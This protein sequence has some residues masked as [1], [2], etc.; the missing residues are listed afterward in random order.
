MFVFSAGWSLS[1]ERDTRL[2]WDSRPVHQVQLVR[3]LA[4]PEEETLWVAVR[5][6]VLRYH[7]SS[8]NEARLSLVKRLRGLLSQ[9]S[10]AIKNQLVA[11]KAPY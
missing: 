11:S 6:R 7:W 5:G 8:Y 10:Y 2:T 1:E 4:G 3:G 9:K